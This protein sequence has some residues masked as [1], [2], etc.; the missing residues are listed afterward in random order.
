MSKSTTAR[1]EVLNALRALAGLK[2]LKSWK[3][4]S[5]KLEAAIAKLT[6][7]KKSKKAKAEKKPRVK[8]FRADGTMTIQNRA[9]TLLREGKSYGDI[10]AAI[11]AEYPGSATTVKCLRWYAAKLVEAGEKLPARPR[12]SWDVTG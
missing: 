10:L 1:L 3:E 2:P 5:A 4:S 7:A 12:T 8:G 6:P 11:A 9:E